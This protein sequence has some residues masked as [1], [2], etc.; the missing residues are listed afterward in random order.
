MRASPASVTLYPRSTSISASDQRISASS[1]T[2]RTEGADF[3]AI[4]GI[5]LIPV[6]SGVE[7][8][9]VFGRYVNISVSAVVLFQFSSHMEPILQ[10][11]FDS[12]VDGI[13]VID[14]KGLIK[15]FNPGAERLFGYRT[16]EVL[17]HNVSM[18]MP[19]P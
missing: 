3:F 12:A 8:H 10:S 16:E 5:F 15:A 18:L 11:I 2:T 9:R 6:S 7:K 19:S 1:S 4:R 14:A 17:G 13:I